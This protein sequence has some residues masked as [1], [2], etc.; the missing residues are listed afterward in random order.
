MK[1]SC[2]NLTA[3]GVND[4]PDTYLE[5]A[6]GGGRLSTTSPDNF[7][8]FSVEI[9]NFSVQ[10][11]DGGKP[12]CIWEEARRHTPSGIPNHR[13]MRPVLAHYPVSGDD[14]FFAAVFDF[15]YNPTPLHY[16]TEYEL[17]HVVQGSGT[18]FIGDSLGEFD[19]GEIYLIGSNLPH[20]FRNHREYYE[21]DSR[22]RHQS[23]TIHFIPE[24]FGAD[25][26][27]LHQLRKVRSLLEQARFGI[28]FS[29]SRHVNV[30]RKLYET[31]EQHGL[32]K[33]L[34]LLEVLDE[35]S[36]DKDIRLIT[37]SHVMGSEGTDAERLKNM[38]Q[39][40]LAHFPDEISLRDIAA[41]ACL[42]RTST[43]RFFKERTRKTIWEFLSEIRLNHAARQLRESGKTI[44]SISGESGFRNISNF[45]RLF[46]Q[47]FGCS[48]KTYRKQGFT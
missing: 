2:H 24:I 26:L 10:F 45:N 36:H 14:G 47:R 23:V 18:R 7:Q 30:V 25:F 6:D 41:V 27:A 20:L 4:K 17:V 13:C 35:L 40:L 9:H 38:I 48:P 16:H 19:K 8:T 39:F 5:K 28:V 1:M 15:P 32:P 34:K 31:T 43:C 29:G 11:G 46:V 33:M 12:M 37:A 22:R 42:T 44:Q 3:I 21:P